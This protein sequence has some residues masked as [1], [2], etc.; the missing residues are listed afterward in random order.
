MISIL[1][2]IENS[3]ED[4]SICKP[5]S[6]LLEKL[7]IL[8]RRLRYLILTPF[9][10]RKPV[11]LKHIWKLISALQIDEDDGRENRSIPTP[12]PS[13]LYT[14]SHCRDYFECKP[15]KRSEKSE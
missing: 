12:T 7:A 6:K 15:T 10:D 3:I 11:N 1:L 13:S 2:Q 8:K 9:E 4:Q 5:C 14:V